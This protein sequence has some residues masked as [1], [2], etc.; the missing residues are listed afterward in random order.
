MGRKDERGA[1]LLILALS[2]TVMLVMGAMAVDLSLWII[3]ANRV[4]KIAGAAA[5]SAVRYQDEGLDSMKTHAY[6]VLEKNGI[7]PATA[8]VSIDGNHPNQVKVSVSNQQAPQFFSSI[9][10]RSPNIGRTAYAQQVTPIALGSPE[11]EIGFGATQFSWLAVNGYCADA[12]EGDQISS[13]YFGTLSTTNPSSYTCDH[14]G[15][16][17]NASYD[18]TGYLYEIDA[19]KASGQFRVQLWNPYFN[20]DDCNFDGPYPAA[21]DLCSTGGIDFRY[22]YSSERKIDDDDNRDIYMNTQVSIFPDNGVLDLSETPIAC[23]T[24]GTNTGGEL[25]DWYTMTTRNNCGYP[26]GYSDLYLNAGQKY[27]VRVRSLK[28]SSDNEW[29]SAGLN[30]F[31]IRT[32][33]SAGYVPCDSRDTPSCITVSGRNAMSIFT[34]GN[35]QNL[36]PKNWGSAGPWLAGDYYLAKVDATH[37][38]QEMLVDLFDPGEGGRRIG[39]QMPYDN[40]CDA[41]ANTDD[42]KYTITYKDAKGTD[43][44]VNSC[45]Y[46]TVGADNGQKTNYDGKSL[47]LHVTLP[48]NYQCSETAKDYTSCWWKVSYL[49]DKNVSNVND[50]TTWGVRSSGDPA[51]LVNENW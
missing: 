32:K 20:D 38:S 42:G 33:T 18:P 25:P 17:E 36:N 44:S 3:Q 50:R 22:P 41:N 46:I 39:L 21:P 45:N 19:S 27:V 23:T 9:F 13:R 1:I 47:R 40:A 31:A 26:S 30:A 4:K 10:M 28:P 35:S 12:A 6:A 43:Q 14:S 49:F 37:A 24:F 11:N 51:F 48:K 7:D 16:T 8:T 15:K 2:L 34:V 29:V 5:L